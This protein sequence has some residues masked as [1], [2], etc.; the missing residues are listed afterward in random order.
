M[1]QHSQT[2][3]GT[4]ERDGQVGQAK[5]HR[6]EPGTR[7]HCHRKLINRQ[8]TKNSHQSS[9]P[10]YSWKA[11]I[12]KAQSEDVGVGI[13]VLLKSHQF[14]WFF[15]PIRVWHSLICWSKSNPKCCFSSHDLPDGGFSSSF[16]FPFGDGKSSETSMVLVSFL[17]RMYIMVSE[18]HGHCSSKHSYKHHPGK[19]QHPLYPST[20]LRVNGSTQGSPGRPHKSWAAFKDTT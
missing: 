18:I 9:S 11:S 13:S 7:C 14:F 6:E 3:Q 20:T 12:V 8:L 2:R 4:R 17:C 15:Y 10:D 5:H 16:T 1:V 19:C